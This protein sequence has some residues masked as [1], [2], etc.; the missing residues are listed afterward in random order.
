[1][2]RAPLTA[3]RRLVPAEVQTLFQ[4]C[5]LEAAEQELVHRQQHAE[6]EYWMRR[7]MHLLERGEAVRDIRAELSGPL[8]AL[9][10]WG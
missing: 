10:V 5:R 3:R 6:L 4:A 9:G 7:A 8:K 1:M 2:H